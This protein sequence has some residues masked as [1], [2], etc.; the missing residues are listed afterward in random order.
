MGGAAKVS[1]AERNATPGSVGTV[2][3]M[4]IV[5]LSLS[6]CVSP[7]PAHAARSWAAWSWAP[8]DFGVARRY[9]ATMRST[10]FVVPA[11]AM[12]T[13]LCSVSAT[14]TRVIARTFE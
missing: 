2:M 7:R 1:T 13:R 6:R 8:S 12:S 3:V 10:W 9:A 11:N 14:T 5:P 4:V